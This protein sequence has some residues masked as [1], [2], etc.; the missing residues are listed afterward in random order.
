MIKVLKM[1]QAEKRAS[2]DI[3]KVFNSGRTEGLLSREWWLVWN[4]LK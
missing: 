3:G 1:I 4:C 2:G